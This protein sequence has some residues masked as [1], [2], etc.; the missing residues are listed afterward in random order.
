MIV[1]DFYGVWGFIDGVEQSKQLQWDSGL[2][3]MNY[4]LEYL[5]PPEGVTRHY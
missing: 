4:G 2:G 1:L 5:V 3:C